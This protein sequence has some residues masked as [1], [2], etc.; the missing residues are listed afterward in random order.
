VVQQDASPVKWSA[1]GDRRAAGRRAW[2]RAS[3]V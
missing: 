1:G 2:M 3:R